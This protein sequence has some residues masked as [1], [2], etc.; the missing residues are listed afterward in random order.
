[1][2]DYTVLDANEQDDI[3]V[4][5][6][7]AQEKD[8][9]CHEINL[10]RYDSMLVVLPDGDWKKRVSGL[11][12]DTVQRLTEVNSIIEATKA[13]MPSTDRIEAAKLRLS[14]VKPS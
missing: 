12:S 3:V 13:Q 4:S 14:S 10:A 11:R 1:M 9:Y 8:K 5:F 2:S 7:L 6:M